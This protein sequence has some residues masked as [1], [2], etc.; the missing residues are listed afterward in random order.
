MFS[1]K[2]NAPVVTPTDRAPSP[3]MACPAASA[4]PPS[5]SASAVKVAIPA[6]ASV[7]S[8]CTL[9]SES[10]R[11]TSTEPLST[12]LSFCAP[13]ASPR[14]TI[15]SPAPAVLVSTRSLPAAATSVSSASPAMVCPV[16]TVAPPSRSIAPVKVEAPVTARAPPTDRLPTIVPDVVEGRSIQTSTPLVASRS[17]TVPAI[18]LTPPPT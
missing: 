15:V 2:S 16:A 13:A 18:T 5:K 3:S 6:T 14:L 9:P 1:V 4:R 8:H 12:M 7:P 10:I 17:I 11:A